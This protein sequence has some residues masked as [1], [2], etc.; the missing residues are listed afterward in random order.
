M[1]Q[2]PEGEA[3]DMPIATRRKTILQTDDLAPGW[4]KVFDEASAKFYYVNT[5]TKETTW[6]RAQ[7]QGGLGRHLST[8]HLKKVV[9]N[10][11]AAS[12]YTVR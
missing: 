8:P 10:K 7:A 9:P 6:S 3:S 11:A 12:A 5:A 2:H 1:D 4:V